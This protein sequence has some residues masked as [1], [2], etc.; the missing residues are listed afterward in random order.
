MW[1]NRR[2]EAVFIVSKAE[3]KQSLL[4]QIPGVD[5]LLEL[6]AVTSLTSRI[7]RRVLV[8]LARE[9]TF[10]LR[11]AGATAWLPREALR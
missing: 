2:R 4:S 5:R 7:D 1:L 11:V 9:A 8:E 10:A 6:P 3:S